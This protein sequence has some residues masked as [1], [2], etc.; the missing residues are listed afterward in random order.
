M[1]T[2]KATKNGVTT[3]SKGKKE[4]I[5]H[6]E[7]VMLATSWVANNTSRVPCFWGE[8]ASGKSYMFQEI[9]DRD[10]A[11]L[12]TVVVKNHNPDDLLGFQTIV[13]GELVAQLP[14]WWRELQEITKRGKKAYLLLEEIGQTDRDQRAALYTFLRTRM[15]YGRS[16]PNSVRIFAATNPALFDY[17][18]RTRI[19]FFHV[20]RQVDEIKAILRG[21]LIL[22][23][24]ASEIKETDVRAIDKDGKNIGQG[25]GSTD[26]P[27]E[28]EYWDM[29][30]ADN[31]NLNL[32]FIRLDEKAQW[33]ILSAFLPRRWAMRVQQNLNERRGARSH[34]FAKEFVKNPETLREL[35][36]SPQLQLD[37]AFTLAS[38]C[39]VALGTLSKAE[40]RAKALFYGIQMGLLE[41]P[42]VE[43]KGKDGKTVFVSALEHFQQSIP[44]TQEEIDVLSKEDAEK[45]RD[46]LKEQG[47]LK[48][49]EGGLSGKLYDLYQKKEEKTKSEDKP[50]RKSREASE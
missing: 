33:L 25:E 50:K 28:P 39:H 47:L 15:V 30:N 42:K 20:H 9:A 12:V 4:E 2:K 27:P 43:T 36:S 34:L 26:P 17:G 10:G 16:L 3:T 45:M 35:L 38:A 48:V 8:S 46:W 6:R 19:A 32:E 23:E 44:P 11:E 14:W 7:A 18:W 41:R 13:G 37:Q 40:D 31:L 21:K 49:S 24:I 22:G 5:S 1:S 29:D